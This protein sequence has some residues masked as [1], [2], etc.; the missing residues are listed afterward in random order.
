[1]KPLR[2]ALGDLSYLNDANRHNLYTPLGIGFLAAYAKLR[3]GRDVSVRLFK[4]PKRLLQ[5]AR[6]ER[7]HLIGLA[8]YYWN[9]RLNDLTG[10]RLRAE[11]DDVVIVAGGPCID[12]DLNEMAD[13][14][15]RRP[16]VD[17]IVPNEGEEAFCNIVEWAMNCSTD[18]PKIG[19]GTSTDLA[20]VPSPYLDGTLDEFLEEGQPFQPLIQTSRLCPYTCLAGDTPVNTIA[21]DI[22]IRML[23]EKYGDAGFPVFTFNLKTW[24]TFLTDSIR[25]RKYGEDQQLVRVH[26]DD[27][28]HLDCTPDH[29]IQLSR[30]R[31][32][33]CEAS[34]LPIGAFVQTMTMRT[35][36]SDI[37]RRVTQVEWLAEKGDVYC[38]TVPE[39]GWFFANNVLVKNCSF[40]VSGKMRGKLRAFPM[41]QV[42]AE[43]EF[44]AKRFADR[45]K[46]ILYIVDENFGILE[47][48]VEVAKCVRRAMDVVGYPRQVFF[49]NDKR[50][51][52][53]SRDVHEILGPACWHG[54]TLSLQSENPETLKAIR[55]RNLT[56]GQVKDAL[57]WAK[58][59]GLKTS[60]E[61]I[62]G[63]PMETRESFLAL[64]D[65]CAAAGFQAIQCYNLII[66]DGI[67]MNRPAYRQ[68]HGLVTKRRLIHGNSGTVDG[69]RVVESEEVVV[70]S[71]SFDADTYRL[72]RSLNVFFHAV[73]VYSVRRRE[74]DAAV[75]NGA[76]VTSILMGLLQPMSDE[77]AAFLDDLA[78]AIDAEL[79]DD[80]DVAAIAGGE[81][82][83][84]T[85]VKI[86]PVFAG[87]IEAAA[88]GW[89]G[90]A[91]DAAIAACASPD[92]AL[93]IA[94]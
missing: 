62:F 87:R 91:I 69:E 3:F 32:L 48:D 89:A 54:V 13:Y 81:R 4:D 50:F 45:P 21:G 23:A 68:A 80:A 44:I 27:G 42:N 29:R 25:I 46:F 8:S 79:L 16:W 82:A 19:Y 26:F 75:A 88:D 33:E 90:A 18:I 9:D 86:Q 38:L 2:I 63:L 24:D 70:S 53:T 51:T 56:D 55:R 76:S 31:L 7:P 20:Q 74:V 10:R 66:F 59:L 34:N 78:A 30:N 61:L 65:K 28:A 92:S 15:G 35:D 14:R 47:R 22:S 94:V 60:T 73:Y 84:P 41:E 17:F 1:M 58:G 83:P 40:C 93:P 5:H 64:L 43:I 57:A 37:D 72:V 49:Y 12:T 71:F 11:L 77:H 52:Q 67:E 85:V 39:Y 36:I 6:D